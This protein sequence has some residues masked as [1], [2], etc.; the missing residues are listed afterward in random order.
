M[1]LL[2]VLSRE[3]F[4]CDQWRM[5]KSVDMLRESEL[6]FIWIEGLSL[7]RD[8]RLLSLES[9]LQE[10][11]SPAPKSH[12]TE[13]PKQGSLTKNGFLKA[14]DRLKDQKGRIQNFKKAQPTDFT[15]HAPKWR[16]KTEN[17]KP[18]NGQRS[19]FDVKKSAVKSQAVEEVENKP[20][21]TRAEGGRKRRKKKTWH[22]VF[23]NNN[24]A[25]DV[26]DSAPNLSRV[27]M[28]LCK[29]LW[30]ALNKISNPGSS[31]MRVEC[32]ISVLK[33]G[34]YIQPINKI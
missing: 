26:C 17:K 11:T 3:C 22:R 7:N 15:P 31:C 5:Q 2:I 34:Q 14:H 18:Q 24:N 29:T 30:C 25:L 8:F 13:R 6:A 4:A 23:S 33:M 16:E 27:Q 20:H 32:N 10:H 21:R 12:Q 28:S 1:L 9:C 19:R